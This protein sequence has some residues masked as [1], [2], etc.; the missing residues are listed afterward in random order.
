MVQSTNQHAHAALLRP[1]GHGKLGGGKAGAAT[2]VALGEVGQ[3]DGNGEGHFL[4]DP[5]VEWYVP[6]DKHTFD[7]PQQ[8]W[9][10]PDSGVL[11]VGQRLQNN[12]KKKNVV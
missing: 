10:E 5:L 11:V 2:L 4:V 6:L 8:V 7:G 1:L 12:T 9:Q 3:Q